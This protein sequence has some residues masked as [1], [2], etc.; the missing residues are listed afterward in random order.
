MSNK[1]FQIDIETEYL[2]AESE[3]NVDRFVF[4]YTIKITN[5]GAKAASLN[6]RHWIITDANGEVS[7]V[8]GQGV[9]GE[10]PRIEPGE[11]YQ[12]TSGA[13]LETPIGTMQ[14]SYQMETDDGEQFDAE[15]PV[16]SLSQP[17]VLH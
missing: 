11:S 12:Y 17:G 6:S 9:V 16:F 10:Q 5:M 1:S 2:I 13:I 3:P 4:A 15:I 14:G 8:K 7:E